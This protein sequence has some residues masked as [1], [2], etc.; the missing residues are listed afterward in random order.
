MIKQGIVKLTDIGNHTASPAA[1]SDHS[2]HAGSYFGE[3]ALIT[4]EPR[5]ATAIAHTRVVLMALDRKSFHSLLGP[6]RE[7]LDSN[8]NVRVLKSMKIFESLTNSEKMKIARAFEYEYFSSG[9]VIVQEGTRGEKMYII[10]DGSVQVECDGKE[11]KQ[12]TGGDYFGEMSL[13]HDEVRKASVIATGD[14]ECFSIDRI[15]FNK[16]L[17]GLHSMLRKQAE[18]RNAELIDEVGKTSFYVRCIPPPPPLDLW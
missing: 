12:L 15:T 13:L 7:I 10:K 1:Y 11:V 16:H 14:V 6:L 4:G 3:R 18:N 5:A 2:L 17:I 8:L 9:H